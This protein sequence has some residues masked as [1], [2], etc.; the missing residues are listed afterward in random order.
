M[1]NRPASIDPNNGLSPQLRPVL[2]SLNVSLENELNRYRRNRLVKDAASDDVFAD[3][4]DETFDINVAEIS[5]IN[6]SASA[7][8][9]PSPPP[10]PPNRRLSLETEDT[11]KTVETS[12]ETSSR[13]LVRYSN[14]A[15]ENLDSIG[16]VSSSKARPDTL[17]PGSI[18]NVTAVGADNSE[19]QAPLGYLESSE[20]LIE[21][22]DDLPAMPEP[23]DVAPKPRRKTVS[24]LAGAILGL[25]G[26]LAGLGVSYV[27][28]SPSMMQK[29]AGL[30]EKQ[31]EATVADAR[32]TFDPPGPDLS[33][34]EFID[35]KLDNLSSLEMSSNPLDPA[36][37]PGTQA[38][39]GL[40]P[41]TSALPPIEGQPINPPTA[42]GIEA[43]VVPTGVTYYV[44]VP[45]T[46]EENLISIRQAI[47]EAFVRSFSDG[48]RIQLAAFDNPTDAQA[49][50]EDVKGQGITAFVYGPTTE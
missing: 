14:I 16:I 15:S 48:N 40:P 34:R 38:L 22:I 8:S 17:L 37:K 11:A 36:A 32:K 47:N 39:P 13:S 20:K 2:S 9:L 12:S 35:L 41:A 28:S 42:N 23:V 29:L 6:I 44:T 7:I 19:P 31:D 10:V 4:N 5:D 46:T 3:L 25:L 45:F 21:S 49:F 27:V 1:V 43:A 18:V 24:L 30:F 50:V 33:Q 26:L